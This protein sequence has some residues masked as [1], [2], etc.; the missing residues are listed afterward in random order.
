MVKRKQQTLW[1]NQSTRAQVPRDSVSAKHKAALKKTGRG[2]IGEEE[3]WGSWQMPEDDKEKP[4]EKAPA[5]LS[6]LHKQTP[7]PFC[8]SWLGLSL[9]PRQR[10]E[11]GSSCWKAL[12]RGKEGTRDCSNNGT[13]G[14][15]AGE[16]SSNCCCQI[17]LVSWLDI[18][19]WPLLWVIGLDWWG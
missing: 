9:P 10:E 14:V 2:R 3:G 5:G 11:A 12:L 13:A 1:G 8:A 17:H 4:T 6:G 18:L 19:F 16:Q 15:R 7:P